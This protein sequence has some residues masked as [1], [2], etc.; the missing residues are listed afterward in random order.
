MSWEMSQKGISAAGSLFSDRLL[1]LNLVLIIATAIMVGCAT[2]AE[3]MLLIYPHKG[4]DYNSIRNLSEK[5]QQVFPYFVKI[6]V[7][8]G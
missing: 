2:G 6:I 1:E 7:Y 8:A 5:T 4:V 3:P